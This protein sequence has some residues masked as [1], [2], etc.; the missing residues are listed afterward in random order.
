MQLQ[1]TLGLLRVARCVAG[2]L[3]FHAQ[4]RKLFQ[5]LPGCTVRGRCD[6]VFSLLSMAS[7]GSIMLQRAC[8]LIGFRPELDAVQDVSVSAGVS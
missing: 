8:R 7:S 6:R 2:Q 4:A 3:E 1:T 5:E